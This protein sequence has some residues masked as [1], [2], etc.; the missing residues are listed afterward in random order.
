[1]EVNFTYSL[2]DDVVSIFPQIQR[3][4]LP[5]R[6]F[7]LSDLNTIL[8]MSRSILLGKGESRSRQ[9]IG[10]ANYVSIEYGDS[11]LK[12]TGKNGARLMALDIK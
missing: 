12:P 2:S 7:M 8:Y 11:F 5:Y 4:L 9:D 10:R 1:V 3:V 6:S